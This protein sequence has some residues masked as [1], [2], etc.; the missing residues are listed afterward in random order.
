MVLIISTI[1]PALMILS[2][3]RVDGNELK[4]EVN[5]EELDELE[6]DELENDPDPDPN[7]CPNPDDPPL[8]EMPAP[9]ETSLEFSVLNEMELMLLT[10]APNLFKTSIPWI[11]APDSETAL[12]P[13]L[14]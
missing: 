14:P 2:S 8:I 6:L 11:E 13:T 12:A 10:K 3:S 9:D 5:E 1:A 7:D 4:T